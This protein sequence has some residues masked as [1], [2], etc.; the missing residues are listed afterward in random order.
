MMLLQKKLVSELCLVTFAA[1][2]S[3]TGNAL[4]SNAA[5]FVT[6]RI[7]L[8]ANDEINWGVLNFG[9]S[10]PIGKTTIAKLVPYSF[11]GKTEQKLGYS[12]NIP[13]LNDT[14][15]PKYTPP[16]VFP[17][18]S[19]IP[20]NFSENEPI[21]FTG[22]I[23]G[24]FPAV[25]NPGPITIS[26]DKPILAVGTQLSVDDALEPYTASISGYDAFDKLVGSFS[27][28]GTSST[29]IDNSAVFLGISSEI[30]NISK[31]VLN[32]SISNRAVAINFVSIK[33]AH[34]PEP[35]QIIALGLVSIIF[36]TTKQ[37]T[38]FKK[39]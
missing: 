6:Q 2:I 3:L 1:S 34:V 9:A 24:K 15:I 31:I 13:N 10:I 29:N 8:N 20:A 22:L 33:S 37:K 19:E 17:V 35:A 25:G 27:I 12:V 11:Q 18:T 16:F 30:A 32:S 36:L 7:D 38:N 23:P 26:F 28:T 14:Q 21:L 39:E 4:P 5:S